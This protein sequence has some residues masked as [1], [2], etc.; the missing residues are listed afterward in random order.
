MRFYKSYMILL[1]AYEALTLEE[2]RKSLFA[3]FI[4]LLV[5]VIAVI[6]LI[7]GGTINLLTWIGLIIFTLS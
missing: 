7:F 2:K 4:T 3:I 5:V 1:V 6:S